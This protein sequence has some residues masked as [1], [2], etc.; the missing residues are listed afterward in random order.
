LG[1]LS[2]SQVSFQQ[3]QAPFRFEKRMLLWVQLVAFLALFLSGG[4]LTVRTL[5]DLFPTPAECVALK[6]VPLF[7]SPPMSGVAGKFSVQAMFRLL[8][9]HRKML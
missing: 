4:W 2:L 3:K 1:F 5:R 7:P 8:A 6:D 9:F